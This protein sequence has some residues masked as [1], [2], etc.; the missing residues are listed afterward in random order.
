MESDSGLSL[1]GGLSIG[2]VVIV[3]GL[4]L[5]VPF[6]VTFRKAGLSPWISLLIF[7]PYVPPLVLM[8]LAFSR[9]PATED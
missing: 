9:W 5:A 2:T 4:I 7:L 8:V 6:W 1:A 3:G